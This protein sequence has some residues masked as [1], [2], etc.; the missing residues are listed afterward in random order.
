M[1]TSTEV[2]AQLVL[3]EHCATKTCYDAAVAAD[4]V[5]NDD[6]DDDVNF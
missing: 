2:A 1:C 3:L 5:D 4:A 6:N